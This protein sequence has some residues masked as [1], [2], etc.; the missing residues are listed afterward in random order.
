M[1]PL[2]MRLGIVP[3][4]VRF[5]SW[6]EKTGELC[7]VDTVANAQ[8]FRYIGGYRLGPPANDNEDRGPRYA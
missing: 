5:D 3:Q 8:L 7:V 2:I 6:S 4:V 1:L